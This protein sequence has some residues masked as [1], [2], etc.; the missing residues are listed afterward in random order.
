MIKTTHGDA[1]TEVPH[2]PCLFA[3]CH[4]S[5]AVWERWAEDSLPPDQDRGRCRSRR[6]RRVRTPCESESVSPEASHPCLR[7]SS[8]P[9]LVLVSADVDVWA[10]A[11]SHFDVWPPHVA[12]ST[13]TY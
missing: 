10:Y 6:R 9:V 4:M 13:S 12:F 11:G 8:G 3:Y 2:S 5:A 7:R 1:S